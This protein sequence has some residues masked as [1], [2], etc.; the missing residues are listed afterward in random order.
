[1][2]CVFFVFMLCVY[3]PPLIFLII[4]SLSGPVEAFSQTNDQKQKHHAIAARRVHNCPACIVGVSGG[5]PDDELRHGTATVCVFV[6]AVPITN[7]LAWGEGDS[8]GHVLRET[9]SRGLCGLVCPS[10]TPTTPMMYVSRS[11][12]GS[13]I[14]V[15]I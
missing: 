10:R 2:H 6:T 15:Q 12:A 3:Q 13:N 1:M 14:S 5:N 8:G 11:L 7:L 9:T 4:K